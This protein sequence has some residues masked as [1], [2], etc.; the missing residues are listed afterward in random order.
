[1]AKDQRTERI[2]KR[3]IHSSDSFIFILRTNILNI[4]KLNYTIVKILKYTNFLIGFLFK[5][6]NIFALLKKIGKKLN[7]KEN[8]SRTY[9]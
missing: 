4:D 5:M 2:V 1:M 6:R 7:S 3:F 8:K 9:Y